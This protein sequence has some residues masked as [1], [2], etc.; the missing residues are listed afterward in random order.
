MTPDSDILTSLED[1]LD[2]L[3][4]DTAAAAGAADLRTALGGIEV[5]VDGGGSSAAVGSG[6]AAPAVAAGLAPAALDIADLIADCDLATA[7]G[8]TLDLSSLFEA[9][10]AIAGL[11][12]AVP[13][14]SEARPANDDRTGAGLEP[15]A[16]FTTAGGGSIAIL[17]DDGSTYSPIV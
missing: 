2:E 13:S 1:I 16:V 9:S 15:A 11:L 14:E 4:A 6:D 10:S 8:D 3:S 17:Y 7:A 12:G 5:V